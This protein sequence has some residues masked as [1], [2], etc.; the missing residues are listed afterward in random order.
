[1]NANTIEILAAILIFIALAKI[2]M[3]V[4]NPTAWMNLI[5]KV[6][7]VPAIVSSVGFLLSLLVLYFIVNSGISIVE[8]LAVCLFVALLMVAGLANYANEFS[9]LIERQG[10]IQIMK[11]MWLYFTAWIFLIGWGIYALM[12]Q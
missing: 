6:Y 2:I 9:A 10:V 1:M 5:N 3:V 7:S 11:K 4:V 12:M 8:I